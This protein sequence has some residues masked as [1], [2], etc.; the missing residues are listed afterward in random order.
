MSLE[1][2][3]ETGKISYRGR[4]IGEHIHKGDKAIVRINL[5]YE[6]PAENWVEPISYLAFGLSMLPE[7][8]PP[9]GGFDIET[10]EDS[11]DKEFNVPRLLIEKLVKRGNYIWKFNKNDVDPW[12]SVLHGHEHDKYLKLD[13]ITGEIYDVGT[14]KLC[15]TL[16][17]KEL[18]Y[19]QDQLRQSGDFK[20]KVQT[21]IDKKDTK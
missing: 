8:Q 13:A 10:G 9:T 12:P 3:P 18:K 17:G 20:T 15:K 4:E 7:N 6:C 11:I 14:R 16:K 21:L 2:N 1:Y 19:V 5:E